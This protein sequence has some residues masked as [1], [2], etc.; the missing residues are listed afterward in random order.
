MERLTKHQ[1]ILRMKRLPGGDFLVFGI[2]QA[3]AALF[4]GLLLAAIIVTEII[5]LPGLARYDWLFLI[6]IVIHVFMLIARL[7]KP[8]E[9]ITI[10][11]FHLVGLGM[12]L[13]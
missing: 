3:W 4:G 6:A 10:V 8:Q 2:K 7:E 1:F 13:F 12:E 11:L 9:V 5:S